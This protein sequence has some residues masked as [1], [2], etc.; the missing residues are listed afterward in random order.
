MELFK[1]DILAD[2]QGKSHGG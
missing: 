2:K 1:G